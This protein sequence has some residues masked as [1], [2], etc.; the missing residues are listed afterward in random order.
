MASLQNLDQGLLHGSMAP[1]VFAIF[2]LVVSKFLSVSQAGLVA[3]VQSQKLLQALEGPRAGWV[4]EVI[5]VVGRAVREHRR[6]GTETCQVRE[7]K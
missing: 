3:G 6:R 1:A 2:F 4:E 7:K 5:Q